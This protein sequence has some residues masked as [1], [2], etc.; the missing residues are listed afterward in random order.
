[1]SARRSKP[2]S[3]T[4]GGRSRPLTMAGPPVSVRLRA[5]R[6]YSFCSTGRVHAVSV[7]GGAAKKPAQLGLGSLQ[8]VLARFRKV[9]PARLTIQHRHRRLERARFAAMALLGRMLER[10]GDAPC[11]AGFEDLVFEVKRVAGF[12]DFD[13]LSALGRLSRHRSSSSGMRTTANGSMFPRRRLIRMSHLV[14]HC[15]A[16]RQARFPRGTLDA[17]NAFAVC[18]K[19]GPIGAPGRPPV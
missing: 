16:Q 10:S 12:S 5:P 17:L 3:A 6:L 15:R 8:H 19:S 2:G 11:T 1:M 7:S 13:R 9:L 18:R 4:A 14:I